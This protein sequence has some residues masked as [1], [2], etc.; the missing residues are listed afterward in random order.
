MSDDNNVFDITEM[1]KQFKNRAEVEK[2]ADHLF[3]SLKDTLVRLQKLES[4]NKQ[5]K[6][7]LSSNKPTSNLPVEIKPNLIPNEQL[8]SEIQLERLKNISI[9]RQ[10]TLDETK[11]FDILIKNLYL[12]KGKPSN[13]INAKS[14]KIDEDVSEA[15]LLQIVKTDNE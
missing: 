5:L 14:R 11:Q 6:E 2:Y 1:S 10:L 15:E 9:D 4:E 12:S 3:V 8:I 7:L 13:T